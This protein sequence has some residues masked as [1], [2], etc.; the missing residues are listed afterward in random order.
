MK[1]NPKRIAVVILDIGIIVLMLVSLIW[2]APAFK[3]RED[4][5]PALAE[6][7]DDRWGE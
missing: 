2:N 7:F 3:T 6:K 5:E 4:P 1:D